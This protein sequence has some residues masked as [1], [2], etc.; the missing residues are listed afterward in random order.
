MNKFQK[1]PTAD[2]RKGDHPKM[3]EAIQRLKREKIDV[4]RPL[5]SD[6]QLKVAEVINF[7]P[8]KGTIFVDGTAGAHE[9][10]GLEAVIDLVAD[11]K[12]LVCS[13]EE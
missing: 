2:I 8:G 12:G 5:N 9:R 7:Y 6:C 1:L 10:R 4:R 13:F 3:V 11:A